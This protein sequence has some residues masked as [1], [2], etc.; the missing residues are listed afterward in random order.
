[1]KCNYSVT[2]TMP[3][4][5][6]KM[7]AICYSLDLNDKSTAYAGTRVIRAPSLDP[8]RGAPRELNPDLAVV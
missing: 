4:I 2:E 1:M 5:K 8:D 6:D 3:F 7:L